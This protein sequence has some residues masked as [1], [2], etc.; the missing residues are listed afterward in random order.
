VRIRE[1]A[2]NRGLTVD[3]FINELMRPASKGVWSTCIVRGARVKDGNL[4]GH[5][6]KVHPKT[7]G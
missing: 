4:A 2:R 6:A 3:E 7:V 1:P 5:V